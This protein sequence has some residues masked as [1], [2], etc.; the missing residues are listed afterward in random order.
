MPIT[1]RTMYPPQKD[2]P[3]TFLSGNIS[4]TD[5]VMT[6]ESTLSLP[7]VVPFPLTL[8]I[9]KT[10]TETVIVTNVN[11]TTNVLTIT[12]QSGSY[13]L[14]RWNAMRSCLYRG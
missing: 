11:S 4:G 5:T 12:R 10:V 6:V 8:G 2:S 9:N 14:G 7:S 13:S 1:K 3:A